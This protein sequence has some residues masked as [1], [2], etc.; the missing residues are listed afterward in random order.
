MKQGILLLISICLLL[1]SGCQPFTSE[2]SAE[3]IG[4]GEDGFITNIDPEAKTLLINS[5]YYKIT[6]Q[7]QIKDLNGEILDWT[8]VQIG[9]KVKTW[10]TGELNKAF[11]N[12]GQA[13]LVLVL[14]DD[15][16]LREREAVT[17]AIDYVKKSES[18]QFMVLKLTHI[19]EEDIY[20][21]ELMKRSNLDESFT[22][23][24]DGET[25]EI[26]DQH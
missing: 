21:I 12:K 11:P 22:V 17:S 7:A 8:D 4:K 9:M 16:S 5:T 2:Q 23:M 18:Q 15:S 26:L 24:V 19:P 20:D 3:A 10:Y 13:K 25:K 6:D 14:T 1:L